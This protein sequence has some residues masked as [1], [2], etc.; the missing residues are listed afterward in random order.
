MTEDPSKFEKI[1]SIVIEYLVKYGFQALLGVVILIVGY[2]LADWASHV[3][4]NVCKKRHLDI[5]LT[6]FF[7]MVV[8]IV[9]IAL[10]GLIALDKFGITISPLLAAVSAAI[11]GA[12]FALQAPLSNYAAGLTIIFTRPFVVGNTIAVKGYSGIVEDIKLPCTILVNGDG[13]HITIPN[14]DIVGEVI[15][16]SFQNKLIESRIGISYADDPARAIDV[17]QRTLARFPQ[18]AK[19][20]GPQIGIASFGEY[21]IEIAIRY[22]APTNDYTKNRH[23]VNLE[24]Y[25]A[26]QSAGITIPY[27]QMNL[28]VRQSD[29]AG[30]GHKN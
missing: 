2:K 8:K 10:A 15:V 12:S 19:D 26:I 22:W 6:N 18:I 30:V 1:Y 14:K 11:F 7:A 9:I 23:D 25:R 28:S 20:P 27:P 17:I 29:G 4:S 5:T 3:F 13:E 21:S 16:N 24:I